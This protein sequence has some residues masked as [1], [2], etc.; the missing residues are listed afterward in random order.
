MAA[1]T[2]EPAAPKK[3]GKRL[4]IVVLS[5]VVAVGGGGAA[6]FFLRPGD[7]EAKTE[8]PPKPPVF[9][10]LESFT[11]NLQPRDG[12]PHYLQAGLTL[13]L[14]DDKA[15]EQVKAQLPE[16]RNR[17]LLLLSAKRSEELISVAGKEQ[18]ATEIGEAV[19]TLIAPP[20]AR[21][22]HKKVDAEAGPDEAEGKAGKA[23]QAEKA[24]KTEK[25]EGEDAE[26]KPKAKKANADA[27]RVAPIEVLFT[28]FIIQ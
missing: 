27:K 6:W 3:G 20:K 18:L 23:E 13:K 2:P 7:A 1:Q 15:G 4:M 5:L 14:E 22:S 19:G 9:L 11:V 17:I 25:A 21:A 24:E 10:A 12:Q 16:V 26:D 8:A 28:S